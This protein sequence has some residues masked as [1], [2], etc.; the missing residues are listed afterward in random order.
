MKISITHIRGNVLVFIVN[1]QR[2]RYELLESFLHPLLV[3][4]GVVAQD[5]VEAGPDV[6]ALAHYVLEG[7]DSILVLT[8]AD[9]DH[10]DVLHDFD[11][12]FFVGV[13]D[14][15][16]RHA[17]E[18]NSFGVVLLFDVDVCHVDFKTAWRENSKSTHENITLTESRKSFSP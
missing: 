17:V 12:H 4:D 10:A 18:F 5:E 15:I 2:D 14:L 16:Q 7:G 13:R 6:G 8:H 9:K 3:P 1:P 11:P